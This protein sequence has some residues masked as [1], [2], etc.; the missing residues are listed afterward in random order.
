M[1]YLKPYN[2]VQIKSLSLEMNTYLKLHNYTK[3]DHTKLLNKGWYAI[4]PINTPTRKISWGEKDLNELKVDWILLGLPRIHFYLINIVTKTSTHLSYRYYL[5]VSETIYETSISTQWQ[6]VVLHLFTLPAH[7]LKLTN[8]FSVNL[9]FNDPQEGSEV[10][11]PSRW[12]LNFRDKR[13]I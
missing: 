12:S 5:R 3:I 11:E 10:H 1:E 4:K 13:L 8:H 2:C 9:V 6:S 7:L